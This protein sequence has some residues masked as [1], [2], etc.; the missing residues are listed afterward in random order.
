MGKFYW[1]VVYHNSKGERLPFVTTSEQEPNAPYLIHRNGHEYR[2][3]EGE[4]YDLI[5]VGPVCTEQ[6]DQLVR[7]VIDDVEAVQMCGEEDV[8]ETWPDLW[9]TYELACAITGVKPKTEPDDGY[10]QKC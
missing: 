5:K 9:E 7:E 3:S 4:F 6:H 10:S 2:P 1:V 8:R